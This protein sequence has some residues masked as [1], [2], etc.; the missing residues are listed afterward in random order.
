MTSE[1]ARVEIDDVDGAAVR[2]GSAHARVSVD[3]HVGRFSVG[4]NDH[5]VAVYA[6][7]YG[8][9]RRLCAKVKESYRVFAL[10]DDREKARRIRGAQHVG[11]GRDEERDR[12]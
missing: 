12:G 9:A 2:A 3:G 4:R 6:D 8:A 5:F 10:V 7:F 1:R 11:A